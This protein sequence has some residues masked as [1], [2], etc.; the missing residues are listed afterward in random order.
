MKF[1]DRIRK[2]LTTVVKH[3]VLLQHVYKFK[4]GKS[5]YTYL[6]EDY[7]K[8]SSIY[9]KN[10]QETLNAL[11]LFNMSA[12]KWK[13]GLKKIDE[14][15]IEGADAKSS[16]AKTQNFMAISQIITSF[17]TA[18]TQL[19]SLM[20]SEQEALFCAFFILEDEEPFSYNEAKN[21]EK[22]S[23]IQSEPLM[24]DFFFII[25]TQNLNVYK[26][27][28]NQSML[29]LLK[30]VEERKAALLSLNTLATKN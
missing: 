30:A 23:L 4:N 9:Y 20:N 14:L 10:I 26:D 25:L 12:E 22:I 11:M 8:I 27:T 3:D 28:L 21:K 6:P 13:V 1:F 2:Q 29:N 18:L 15:C 24:Q 19:P 16:S 17:Q 7:G 5:I